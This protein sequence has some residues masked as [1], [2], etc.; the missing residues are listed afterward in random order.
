MEVLCLSQASVFFL[1]LSERSAEY[2]FIFI[3]W[4]SWVG[5]TPSS[6]CLSVLPF[7]PV[8]LALSHHA[9]VFVYVWICVFLC[10]SA[11]TYMSCIFSFCPSLLWH[12]PTRSHPW[13]FYDD[14]HTMPKSKQ[15][16]NVNRFIEL[17]PVAFKKGSVPVTY[18]G[19]NHCDE[20]G[21]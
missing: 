21:N 3:T 19:E 12:T 18:I 11:H 17:C 20:T 1:L 16:W 8:A 9:R 2:C 15:P 13:Q 14:C 6:S 10:V 4:P 5:V 7:I